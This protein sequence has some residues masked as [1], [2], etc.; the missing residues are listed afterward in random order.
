[1]S[2]L[3][4]RGGRLMS[5]AE[6]L[7][8]H[9]RFLANLDPRTTTQANLRRAVSAAYYA[10]FHLF[11][12]EVASQVSPTAPPGMRERTQRAL[13]RK[14]MLTVAN[15]FSQAGGRPTSL[16]AD[17]RLPDP[18]SRELSSI[19]ISFKRIQEARHLADYDVTNRF[20]PV[21]ALALVQE[22]ERIFRDWNTERNSGNA[23]AFLASMMFWKLWN[24]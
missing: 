18:I 4:R 1:M 12:A 5:L 8:D 24:K 6:E 19:A 21:D 11:S 3:R 17:I 23:Q 15:A 9:A 2:G 16:P 10:V 13:E 22:A 20:D 7:L 14:Q